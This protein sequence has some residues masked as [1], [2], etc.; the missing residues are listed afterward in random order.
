[1]R[2]FPTCKEFVT[3]MLIILA[4][5]IVLI[6]GSWFLMI[7]MPS[8]SFQGL[9]PPLTSTETKLLTNL[10][11]HVMFLASH[12]LGRNY[13]LDNSLVPFQDYI[14]NQ[15]RTYGYQ[16]S[17]QKYQPYVE[18]HAHLGD[19]LLSQYQNLDETY[20]NLEVEIV[21]Q[22]KPDEIIILGAHY[23]SV[24]GSPG[25]NDNASGVAALLE[26]AR[27]LQGQVLSRTVRFIAFVNEEP[28]FFQTKAMGSY[29]YAKRCAEK[30]ENIVGII[31]LETIG[32]F[33]NEPGSQKYPPPFSFFYPNQGNF[34][35]FVG[36]LSSRQLVRETLAIFRKYAL[37][38][39]EGAAIPAL[40]P[41][42]GWSD[43]WAFWQYGYPAIMITDTA[44]YR[45][46][47]YHQAQD[48]PDKIDYAKMMRVVS[49]VQK[50][51]EVLA[52]S[53]KI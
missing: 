45:Y 40:I 37:I 17:L 14:I 8:A 33:Q 27:M 53:E 26:I 49:G 5:T 51:I 3:D 39:S 44:P 16:V 21:G 32:Y 22:D 25:A 20:A 43:H 12:S 35:G 24:P 46:P 29:V 11:A 18:T 50:I 28:P 4:I 6:I 19:E 1:M 23:D 34:I 30:N 13:Y 31:V 10:K 47:H 36:N 9:S 42:V 41:G 38:P 52:R 7:R 15:F 48:T 2:I